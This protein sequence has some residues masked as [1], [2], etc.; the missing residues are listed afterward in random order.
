[1]T[2]IYQ[3]DAFTTDPFKGNPAGVCLLTEEPSA[4]WMQAIAAEMNV[5]ETVFV[6]RVKSDYSVRYFTPKVEVPLCGHATLSAA[7]VLWSEGIVPRGDRILFHAQEEDLSAEME[8]G[9]ICMDFPAFGVKPLQSS[10]GVAEALNSQLA[11]VY[12]T[13]SDWWLAELADERE[14]RELEPDMGRIR[15]VG[16][17]VVCVTARSETGECDFVSRFFAP[18]LGVDED[19]V[20]G[21]A[22]CMLGPFW[23]SRLDRAELVGHQVSSRGGVVRVRMAGQRVKILGQAVGI[24]KGT[25]DV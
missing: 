7:H 23:Q 16:A 5:S 11:G 22:H 1:M 18:K 4:S 19:P 14:V 9:W 6:R 10:S 13:E 20:T 24:F 12:A 8:E 17:Q 15:E 3:V 25:L 2:W 21:A